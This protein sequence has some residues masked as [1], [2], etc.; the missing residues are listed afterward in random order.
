MG[1]A[2]MSGV[3]R[4]AGWWLVPGLVVLGCAGGCESA[5]APDAC[6]EY[7]EVRARAVDLRESVAS[8]DSAK[9]Q[10]QVT[11]FQASLDQFQ[12]ASEGTADL[13]VDAVRATAADIARTVSAA[14]ATSLDEVRSAAEQALDDFTLDWE[15]LVMSMDQQCAGA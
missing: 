10:E 15:S 4:G 9:I 13:A 1:G 5:V 3:R 7:E 8:G 6:G 2:T 14:D 12:A 11:S